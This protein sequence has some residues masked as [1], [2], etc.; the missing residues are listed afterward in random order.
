MAG[1]ARRD[2]PA[3]R[4]L[5]LSLGLAALLAL[6]GYWGPLGGVFHAPIDHLLDGALAPFRNLYKFEPVIAVVLILGTAHAAAR[7]WQRRI[8]VPRLPRR[9]TSGLATAPVTALVL[10]GLALPYLSGQ[11][12]Q[13][14]SF[15]SV[16]RYWYQVADFLAAHSTQAPALVVPADAHGTY[17][18][19]NPIDDPLEPLARS[20]WVERGLVPYGGAGSQT[21]LVPRRAPSNPASR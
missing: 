19:G 4:W 7:L 8:V 12:L 18:W 21:V 20:P 13:P 6:A 2:M 11:I 15:T 14:G 10:A 17:L 9:I 3:G 16:P 5:R 1:L